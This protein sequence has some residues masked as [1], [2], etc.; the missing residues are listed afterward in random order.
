[1]FDE[2]SISF[3]AAV[4]FYGAI[5]LVGQWVYTSTC[6]KYTLFR[7]TS[8]QIVQEIRVVFQRLPLGGPQRNVT[9]RRSAIRDSTRNGN[10][11]FALILNSFLVVKFGY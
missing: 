6:G 2:Y 4:K 9:S 5:L 10:P 11:R 1:M 3:E 7:G 8:Y